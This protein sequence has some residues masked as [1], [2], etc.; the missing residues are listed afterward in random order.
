MA[1]KKKG[2]TPEERAL[3][4]K[5]KGQLA[6]L[7]KPPDVKMSFAHVTEV[8]HWLD[9][10]QVVDEFILSRAKYLLFIDS[11]PDETDQ[12]T[13]EYYKNLDPLWMTTMGG[14]FAGRVVR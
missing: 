13:V 6:A 7:S 11:F 9:R 3:M 4:E 12:L 5:V 2:P 1:K 14:A 8:G 10:N